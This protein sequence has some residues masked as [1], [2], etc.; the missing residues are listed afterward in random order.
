MTPIP[1]EEAAA[2]MD[3]L[4]AQR[5]GAQARLVAMAREIARL[6]AQVAALTPPDEKKED[7]A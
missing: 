2:M 6:R 5:D 4:I 1:A 3:E 7:A